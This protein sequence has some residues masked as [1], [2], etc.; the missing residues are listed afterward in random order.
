MFILKNV[1]KSLQDIITY[2]LNKIQ[3]DHKNFKNVNM[4]TFFSL[5]LIQPDSIYN[6]KILSTKGLHR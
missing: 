4:K 3:D 1:N 6:K 2:I 5:S